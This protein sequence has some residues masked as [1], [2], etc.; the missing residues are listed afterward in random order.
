MKPSWSRP[1]SK[2]TVLRKAERTPVRVRLEIAIRASALDSQNAFWSKSLLWLPTQ[3]FLGVA[4]L[5]FPRSCF[6]TFF[7]VE[8]E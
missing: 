2:G 7:L 4:W 1:D 6:F 5:S 3:T 8:L